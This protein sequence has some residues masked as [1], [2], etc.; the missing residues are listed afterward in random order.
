V[1]IDSLL[2][3]RARMAAVAVFTALAAL[4]CWTTGVADAASGQRAVAVEPGAALPAGAHDLGPVADGRS[5]SFDVVLKPRDPAALT[6]FVD[7]VST[8]GSPDYRDYLAQG[9]FGPRFGATPAAA[10]AVRSTLAQAGLHPGALSADGLLLPVTGTAARIDGGLG[11]SL[12]QVRLKSGKVVAANAAAVKLPAA[13]SGDVEAVVGLDGLHQFVPGGLASSPVP[14]GAKRPHA[15]TTNGTTPCAAAT[16][17]GGWTANQIAQA[18]DL[19]PI[20]SE[21]HYGG[22]QTVALLELAP[23]RST[24][25]AA[26]QSCYGTSA[27]VTTTPIIGGATGA[28]NGED[29]IDIE[30]VIGLAPH[31]AVDV[32]EAPS[33]ETGW[34]DAW[35]KIAANDSAKEVSD[36]WDNCEFNNS[37]ADLAAENTVLQEMASQG[38]S[39]FT[40]S[41]DGGA[42]CDITS[43]TV[44]D[45]SSQP[46]ITS[47]GG[48]DLNALGNPPALAPSETAWTSSGGGV[49]SV[50]PMPSYQSGPGVINSYSTGSLC[51]APKG[52][53]CREVPDV[54]ADAGIGYSMYVGGS[55]GNWGGTSLSS[56]TWAAMTALIN[57]SSSSCQTSPVGFLNPS[58]YALAQS[59]PADFNDVTVGNNDNGLTTFGDRYPA[60]A[61]YDMATGLGSPAGANLAQSLC[62]GVL[63]TP[64][65]STSTTAA[66]APA[67]AAYDGKLYVAYR[68]GTQVELTSYNGSSWSPPSVVDPGGIEAS[69]DS[70]PSIAVLGGTVSVLWTDSSTND[71]LYSAKS[72]SGTWS[73][74]VQVGAGVALSSIGP[75]LSQIGSSLIAVWKDASTSNVYY[76][77][78]SSGSWSK[79]VGLSGADSIGIPAATFDPHTD[80]VLIAWTTPSDTIQFTWLTLL[81]QSSVMTAPGGTNARPAV[82]AVG[83][84]FYVGW[85][86]AS[87]DDVFYESAPTSDETDFSSQQTIPSAQTGAGP[88]FAVSGPSLFDVWSGL[89]SG[90]LRWSASDAPA[91]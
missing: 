24:D 74:A 21:N 29:M 50:W 82:A 18:Y 76:S 44:G 41:G 51:G 68:N 53:D 15:V 78:L 4:F 33:T 25:V 80:S 38:Q 28:P 49:S 59:A 57:D 73:A 89:S 36:S 32:Y 70:S 64:Q 5:F 86:G 81:G 54:S 14:T 37:S 1:L 12:H 87:T 16:N 55:W 10:A 26:F 34:L 20:Y 91:S 69:T 90:D 17:P 75:A 43:L 71:V 84:R 62:G 3:G 31:A 61:G 72:G 8:P 46:Y 88:A 85:K 83:S 63:W 13:I 79:Q 52:Q 2:L 67:A 19:D 42:Q 60:T 56:P 65:A 11:T 40:S 30:D 39:V 48:T 35:D 66:G 27:T 58:L 7:A 77:A 9:Q 23:W 22:G 47:V 6:A 45:P